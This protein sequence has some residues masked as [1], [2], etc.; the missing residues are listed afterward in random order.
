MPNLAESLVGWFM[1][2]VLGM[3]ALASASPYIFPDSINVESPP[4]PPPEQVP[5][6]EPNEEPD[7]PPAP[8]PEYSDCTT[9]WKVTTYGTNLE[10]EYVRSNLQNVFISDADEG[11]EQNR[12]FPAQFMDDVAIDGSG[13]TL[14]GDYLKFWDD[15]FRL[16]AVSE[17]AGGV[18]AQA[19]RTVA[20]DYNIYANGTRVRIIS[21]PL[22]Y[23][24]YVY[25]VEDQFGVEHNRQDHVVAGQH[26]HVD[27]YMGAGQANQLAGHVINT[28]N[29]TLCL[30]N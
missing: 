5:Q 1:A 17:T 21:L 22:G 30:A 9:G 3:V 8:E 6:P 14:D 12:I 4:S 2:S 28:N 18:V 15:E 7:S 11:L 10:S 24:D 29:A 23:D 27:I 13:L 16:R 19:N 25:F 26:R 20:I